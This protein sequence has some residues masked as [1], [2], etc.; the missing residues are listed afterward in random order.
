MFIFINNHD[1]SDAMHLVPWNSVWL[2]WNF[3]CWWPF[4]RGQFK[5]LQAAASGEFYDVF[6][7]YPP[8]YVSRNAYKLSNGMPSVLQLEPLPALNILAD[9]F[10][11][12]SPCLEDIAVYFFPTDSARSVFAYWYSY[13]LSPFLLWGHYLFFNLLISHVLNWI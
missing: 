1:T 13:F 10:Q 3:V 5:I 6:E 12:D 7:A 11:N 2:T 9:V 8:C 4:T